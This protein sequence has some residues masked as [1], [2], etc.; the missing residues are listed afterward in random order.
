MKWKTRFVAAFALALLSTG[1]TYSQSAV[2]LPSLPDV[3]GWLFHE[4]TGYADWLG[5]RFFGLKLR[6]PINVILVDPYSK[7]EKDAIRKVIRE[8]AKAGYPEE[9]GH[10]AGYFGIIDG[11]PY[12]QVNGNRREAFS[13]H[14]FFV[15]NNHGRIIGP[16]QKDGAFIFIAAF[17]TEKPTVFRGFHHLFVSFNLARDDFCAK[18]DAKSAFKKAGRQYLGNVLH[19]GRETTAD[20]DGYATILVANE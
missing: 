11:R 15:L 12:S 6:E 14:D 2:S 1:L 10:S 18:L 7:T 13:N 9:F 3:D 17:S 16:A 19:D 20:H 4:K 5:L 8:C